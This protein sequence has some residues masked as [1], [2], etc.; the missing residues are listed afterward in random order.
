MTDFTPTAAYAARIRQDGL[1]PVIY[2]DLSYLVYIL[3]LH[4][5]GNAPAPAV[6]VVNFHRHNL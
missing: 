1:R 2:C 6:S 3:Y 4:L 5:S